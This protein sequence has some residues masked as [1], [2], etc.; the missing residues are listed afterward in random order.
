MTVQLEKSHALIMAGGTGGHIFP[1]IAVAKSLQQKGWCVSWLGSKGGMEEQ[2]VSN[3]G[4][5]LDV[6]SVKGLRGNGLVG[7]LKLPFTLSKAILEARKIIKNRKPEVVIGFGGFVS[8]PGGLA[9]KL[10]GRNLI[11]HEQNAIAGMTNKFLAKIATHIFEA[12]PGAFENSEKVSTVGNPVR[13]AIIDV[14]LNQPNKSE[15]KVEFNILVI[16]GSRGA[17]ALN[18]HLPDSF[19]KVVDSDGVRILHQVGK[20][21]IKETQEFYKQAG[22]ENN[23]RV[24]LLEFIEDMARAIGKA[25]LIVCRAGA[26]T[27]SEVAAAGKAAIFIPYPYAVDDHQTANAKWLSENDAALIISEENLKAVEFKQKLKALVSSPEKIK[28]MA[29]NAKKVAMLNATEQI[30]DYCERFRNKA[31]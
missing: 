6:I 17:L 21:R 22:L 16:G 27:V 9:S 7:W 14:G 11:I 12:F 26:S 23:P 5:S 20:G 13:Q 25:D 10:S 30:V 8:G 1:G 29:T 3:A 19:A 31:A 24:E 4:I 28:Q 15:Q 18:K 2:L